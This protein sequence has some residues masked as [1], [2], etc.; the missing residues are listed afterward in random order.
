MY[1]CIQPRLLLSCC[2]SYVLYC[3]M[4]HDWMRPNFSTF[5]CCTITS[6]PFYSYSFTY[7]TFVYVF[8]GPPL[9]PVLDWRGFPVEIIIS[10]SIYLS[11]RLCTILS[12]STYT[13][14]RRLGPTIVF[15]IVDNSWE[16]LWCFSYSLLLLIQCIGILS[17]YSHISVCC[18]IVDQILMDCLQWLPYQRPLATPLP[19]KWQERHRTWWAPSITYTLRFGKHLQG[20]KA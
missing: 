9:I 2:Y 5:I 3:S 20:G 18:T 10:L 1:I 6:I 19:W 13:I 12:K 14:A 16:D 15:N 11:N 7:V 4:L 17:F 8:S